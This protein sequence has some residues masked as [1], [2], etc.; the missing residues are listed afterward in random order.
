MALGYASITNKIELGM[1]DQVFL[2]LLKLLTCNS[3]L[4]TLNAVRPC[5]CIY[6]MSSG[7]HQMLPGPNPTTSIYNATNSLA[8]FKSNFFSYDLKT[9]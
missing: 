3:T 8:R 9:L 2:V 1:V 7:S 6:V 5:N 4:H